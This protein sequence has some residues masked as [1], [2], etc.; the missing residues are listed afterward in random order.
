MSRW[1]I[2]REWAA[3]SAVRDLNGDRH[4]AGNLGQSLLHEVKERQAFHELHGDERQ[5]VLGLADVVHDADVRMI[6]R[7][8][9][10][11][12]GQESLAADR[13]ARHIGR[14]E[15]DRRLAIQPCVF[16]QEHFPHPARASLA[17]MR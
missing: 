9:G 3:S 15:L 4:D 10:F 12:L 11:G 14:Q 8:S 16:G 2:R 17:V 13:I 1:T 7:R 6:E 5:S